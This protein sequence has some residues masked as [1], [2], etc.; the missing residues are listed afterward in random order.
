MVN[1]TAFSIELLDRWAIFW[2]YNK[3]FLKNYMIVYSESRKKFRSCDRRTDSVCSI[4]DNKRQTFFKF[5]ADF[6]KDIQSHLMV[7]PL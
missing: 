1:M 2:Y 5:M 7:I 4:L 3:I 6:L